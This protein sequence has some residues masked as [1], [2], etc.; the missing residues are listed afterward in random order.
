MSFP[1]RPV[2]ASPT[3]GDR[4]QV[5]IEKLA[6]G[7]AGIA[8]PN[9]FVV[10]VQDTA[11]GDVVQVEITAF[12]KNH[13]EAKVLEILSPGVGRRER[14]CVYAIEC[15]GCNW[16]HLDESTQQIW[17][18]RLVLETLKK[19]LPGR[20]IPMDPLV[21]S[22]K[23]FF[24]RN[25][26]QPRFFNGHLGYFKRRKHEFLPVKDCLIV[27]EPL[28]KYF[29]ESNSFGELK[30]STEPEKI[31]LKVDAEGNTSWNRQ[32]QESEGFA[33]SQVNRFQNEDLLQTVLDWTEGLDP[34]E[35][36]DLYAGA[37]NFTFPLAKKFSKA[38]V[39]AVEL[40][41]ALVKR[42]REIVG[43]EKRK[44][45]NFVVSQVEPWLQRHLP[46]AGSLVILDPPR[47]GAG[48]G[49]MKSLASS[50][51]KTILYIACHPVSLARDLASLFAASGGKRWRL[52]QVR[53]FEMFPQTD[54]ME[55]IAHL[56]V[57]SL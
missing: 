38:P 28:R 3:V 17:K 51:A 47:A 44:G 35:V 24:Y 37:G 49:V 50:E 32:T 14:P 2:G 39:T 13:A 57:D 16:Q 55:T 34:S 42:A 7:G 26:V 12:H 36:W 8:R 31:E 21:P 5:E 20:E 10:F 40:S 56:E 33:F 30:N 48:D 53:A 1:S 52:K 22:P 25:R 6:I 18:E 46:K 15:G 41:S 11:P 19:F 43:E 27:E 54:H 4:L 9:G 45:L 29:S 23:S